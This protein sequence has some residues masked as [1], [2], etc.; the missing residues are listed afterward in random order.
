[1]IYPKITLKELLLLFSSNKYIDYFS[2][3]NTNNDSFP[4]RFRCKCEHPAALF[5]RLYKSDESKLLDRYI[6]YISLYP[7]D[8]NIKEYKSNP[9]KY[10]MN[11]EFGFYT[12]EKQTVLDR[13]YTEVKIPHAAALHI[14]LS[15]ESKGG[16]DES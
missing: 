10:S 9:N 5:R 11:T 15:D 12:V 7:V 3:V 4:D 6:E 16:E 1:M 14:V 8:G 13:I 2:I